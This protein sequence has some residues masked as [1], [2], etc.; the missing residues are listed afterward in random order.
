MIYFY[1]FI[2]PLIGFGAAA[3]KIL[4]SSAFWWHGLLVVI[5]WPAVLVYDGVFALVMTIDD[6]RVHRSFRRDWRKL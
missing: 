4:H 2:Y 6:W 3:N 1:L 5:F